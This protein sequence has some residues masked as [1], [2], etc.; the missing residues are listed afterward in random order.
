MFFPFF[1]VWRLTWL[2]MVQ[3]QCS[4]TRHSH[5]GECGPFIMNSRAAVPSCGPVTC[6]DSLHT[7]LECLGP[8]RPLY[9]DWSWGLCKRLQR[10]VL[11]FLENLTQSPKLTNDGPSGWPGS[12][13]PRRGK[14]WP[15]PRRPCLQAE[16]GLTMVCCAE[17]SSIYHTKMFD[18]PHVFM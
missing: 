7:P 2:M 9:R 18:S 4:S 15:S 10:A 6:K 17:Y 13:H 11:C 1:V 3:W 14:A 8:C 16:P 5:P 12:A